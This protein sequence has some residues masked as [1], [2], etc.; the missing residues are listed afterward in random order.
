FGN[1]VA[2]A[3]LDGEPVGSQAQSGAGLRAGGLDGAVGTDDPDSGDAAAV[4]S[5]VVAGE[6]LEAFELPDTELGTD[7]TRGHGLGPLAVG[8]DLVAFVLDRRERSAGAVSTC[9]GGEFT[10]DDLTVLHEHGS[11]RGPDTVVGAWILDG[12]TGVD[13]A[14]GGVAGLPLL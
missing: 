13:L 6:D 4:G 3:F 1:L 10:A 5:E 8:C 2:D 14:V 9:G 7:L 11:A 12:R